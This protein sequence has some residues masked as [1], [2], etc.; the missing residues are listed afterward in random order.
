MYS[1]RGISFTDTENSQDSRRRT[2]QIFICNFARETT[3][4][5]F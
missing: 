5:Y 4:T 1:I 2:Q 3:I